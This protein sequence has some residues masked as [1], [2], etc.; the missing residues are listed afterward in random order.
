M[1]EKTTGGPAHRWVPSHGPGD[2]RV[3]PVF[4]QGLMPRPHD[5]AT[6]YTVYSS[7]ILLI[8]TRPCQVLL[9]GR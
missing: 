9:L 5:S 1:D 3:P 8:V 2:I 7:D 4:T 6:V